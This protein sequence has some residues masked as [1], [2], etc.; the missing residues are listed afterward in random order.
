MKKTPFLVVGFVALVLG[1][2]APARFVEPLEKGEL[3]VGGSLGG[4]VISFGGPIPMPLSSVEVGYGLDTNL[5]V[6]VHSIQPLLILGIYRSMRG[7]LTN[8]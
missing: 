2:C 1:A 4:P 7:F 8:F 3:T 6:L 5:T